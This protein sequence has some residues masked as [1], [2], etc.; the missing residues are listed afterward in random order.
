MKL[1]KFNILDNTE[2]VLNSPRIA[3][4]LNSL[5]TGT[6]MISPEFFATQ[7]FKPYFT[8]QAMGHNEHKNTNADYVPIQTPT[9]HHCQSI[10][11]SEKKSNSKN[12]NHYAEMTQNSYNKALQVLNPTTQIVANLECLCSK[13]L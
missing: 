8:R 13:F 9:K 1:S 7:N 2:K 11:N 3:N 5:S 10:S 12:T 4:R 6:N